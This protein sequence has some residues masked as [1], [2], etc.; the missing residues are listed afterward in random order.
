MRR[1]LSVD[2]AVKLAESAKKVHLFL[3]RFCAMLYNRSQQLSGEDEKQQQQ[4]QQ[5]LRGVYDASCL[6]AL[7]RIVQSA[8]FSPTARDFL[9]SLPAV[10]T[11]CINLLK[12]LMLTGPRGAAETADGSYGADAG[13]V[14]SLRAR[15]MRMEA[16]RLIGQLVFASDEAASRHALLHLL[17]CSVS[18]DFETRSRTV[19]LLIK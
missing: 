6:M 19:T 3:M 11:Q 7:S 1:E 4:Q 13:A 15:G 18:A 2:P 8:Y 14:P 9:L 12:L 10:P 16:L 17:W 5:C